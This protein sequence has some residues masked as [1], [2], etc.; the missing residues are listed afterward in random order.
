MTTLNWSP[1]S[2]NVPTL[3]QSDVA[4]FE[5]HAGCTLPTAYTQLLLAHAGHVTDRERIAVG[6]GDTVFGAL[7]FVSDDAV[8]RHHDENAYKA[9]DDL[10]D[11]TG[12]DECG[13][14]P[15]A[16]NTASGLFCFDFR[17]GDSS[18]EPAVVFADLDRDPDGQRAVLPV[19]DSLADFLQKL[20]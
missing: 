7:F 5:A 10:R 3:S 14:V 18:G 1:Y 6:N 16:S 19:A 13:L 17:S 12:K 15:F 2:S 20:H 9:L 11:W 8:Y 4:A